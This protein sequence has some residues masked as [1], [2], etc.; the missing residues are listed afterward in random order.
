M[1]KT[2]H[3]WFPGVSAAALLAAMLGGMVTDRPAAAKGAET[4]V[5]GLDKV[6]AFT[7][8]PTK[9]FD[10]KQLRSATP[11]STCC[12]RPSRKQSTTW[13][14]RTTAETHGRWS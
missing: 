10:P 3:S 11:G 14:V 6:I 12:A 9:D 1:V 13:W 8:S 5:L 4:K 2:R 7:Y